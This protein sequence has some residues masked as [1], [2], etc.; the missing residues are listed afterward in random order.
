MEPIMPNNMSIDLCCLL[1]EVQPKAS[2]PTALSSAAPRR[3][4]V[5]QLA[6]RGI[7]AVLTQGGIVSTPMVS[8]FYE[9]VHLS[10]S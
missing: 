7:T 5:A 8:K 9:L 1:K 6:R 2:T 10:L 3:G 4:I